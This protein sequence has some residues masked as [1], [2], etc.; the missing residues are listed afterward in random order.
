MKIYNN[1]QTYNIDKEFEKSI[2]TVIKKYNEGEIFIHP[3]DTVYS[4]G[5]NPLLKNAFERLKKISN[6]NLF[7]VATL[8]INSLSELIFYIDIISEKHFDFLMS[9]WPN[10]VR[11]IFKLNSKFQDYFES[12]TAIFQIPNNRFCLRMLTEIGN[13]LL[14]IRFNGNKYSSNKNHELLTEEYSD[15]VDAVFYTNSESFNNESSLVDLTSKEPVIIKESKIKIQKF[16]DKYH[17]MS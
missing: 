13:P 9:I 14:S 8:L 15:I 17:L 2:D 16:I 10:P 12:N 7:N 6:N 4:I 11:V 5:G 3:T 1:I